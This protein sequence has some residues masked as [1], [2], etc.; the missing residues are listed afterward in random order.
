MSYLMEA[1][2]SEPG[3]QHARRAAITER[4]GWLRTLNLKST[5][6]LDPAEQAMMNTDARFRF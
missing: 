2:L 6:W 3:P 5:E 1:V 4:H